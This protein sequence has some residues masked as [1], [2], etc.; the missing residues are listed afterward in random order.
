MK[1]YRYRRTKEFKRRE[2]LTLLRR[3]EEW[4]SESPGAEDGKVAAL[5]AAYKNHL[6]KDD[7]ET[8]T[9]QP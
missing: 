1:R 7:P 9:K 2:M 4:E 8:T 6:G 5:I 3:L